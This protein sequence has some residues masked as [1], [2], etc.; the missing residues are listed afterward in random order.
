MSTEPQS[1]IASPYQEKGKVDII[2]QEIANLSSEI[3]EAIQIREL[4]KRYTHA[5]H[6]KGRCNLEGCDNQATHWLTRSNADYCRS[7][8][9]CNLHATIWMQVK[10]LISQSA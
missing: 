7:D 5:N 6:K 3:E 9:V 10:D 8:M 4:D 1:A 2:D